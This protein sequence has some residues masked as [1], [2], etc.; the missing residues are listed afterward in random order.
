MTPE[1][2]VTVDLKNILGGRSILWISIVIT[3]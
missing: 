1:Y 2:K 3:I